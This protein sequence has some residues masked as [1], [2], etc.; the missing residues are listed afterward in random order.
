VFLGARLNLNDI[1]G[2]E[3]LAG[4]YHDNKYQTKMYSLEFKRRLNEKLKLEIFANI[5]DAKNSN[6]FLYFQ[7]FDSNATIKLTYYFND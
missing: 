4:I 5:N 2:T 1:E 6:D 3:M 7:R